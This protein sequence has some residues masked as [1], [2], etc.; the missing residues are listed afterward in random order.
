MLLSSLAGIV[1]TWL[2]SITPEGGESCC[3]TSRVCFPLGEGQ[4]AGISVHHSG[5]RTATR[6]MDYSRFHRCPAS[7]HTT[8]PSCSSLE[9]GPIKMG[10]SSRLLWSRGKSSLK[11]S[12]L[13]HSWGLVPRGVRHPPCSPDNLLCFQ[14]TGF[15]MKCSLFPYPV[16]FLSKSTSYFIF[17]VA[18]LPM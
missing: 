4:A 16:L 1:G 2:V 15:S 17:P 12:Y 18:Y 8:A 14:G 5:V 3:Q 9:L 10:Q 7:L 13:P 6:H 11:L